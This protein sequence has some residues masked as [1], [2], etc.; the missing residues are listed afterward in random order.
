MSEGT[1][2]IDQIFKVG[3]DQLR[4]ETLIKRLELL[5]EDGIEVGIITATKANAGTIYI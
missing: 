1:E 4:I 3:V 5:K 2:A